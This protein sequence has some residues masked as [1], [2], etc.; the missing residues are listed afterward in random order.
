MVASGVL[1]TKGLE[2]EL[3]TRPFRL[4]LAMARS[5][6]FIP[7]MI[8]RKLLEGFEHGRDMI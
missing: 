2:K 1:E 6:G 8:E 3:G 5:L 4:L 7:S